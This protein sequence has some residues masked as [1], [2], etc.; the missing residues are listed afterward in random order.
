MAVC[1]IMVILMFNKEVISIE[2]IQALNED[3]H[4]NVISMSSIIGGFLFTGF[5]IILSSAEK[6]RIKRLLNYGYLN[7]WY[8]VSIIG[9]VCD[10]VSIIM[11]ISILITTL[12]QYFLIYVEIITVLISIVLFGWNLLQILHLM[13]LSKE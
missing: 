4:Y 11:A 1:I 6:D 2:K 8:V 7:N 5:S 12:E 10:I 3:F 13:K 9:I